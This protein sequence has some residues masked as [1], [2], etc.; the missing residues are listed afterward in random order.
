MLALSFMRLSRDLAQTGIYT[1]TDWIVRVAEMHPDV[2]I[3]SMSIH[4]Y[5]KDAIAEL[6]KWSAKG[7]KLIK[8][9]QQ[10]YEDEDE[11]RSCYR[12]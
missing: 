3:P 11:D 2:F 1:P 5:R 4:P 6:E 12:E 10:Q 9:M 8:C 7:I